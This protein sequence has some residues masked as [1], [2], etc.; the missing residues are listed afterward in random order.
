MTNVGLAPSEVNSVIRYAIKD[1]KKAKKSGEEVAAKEERAQD[2]EESK[3]QK[4]DALMKV[5]EETTDQDV[6]DAIDEKINEINATGE[7]KEQIK[8]KNKEESEL[9]KSLLVD[10]TTGVEYDTESELKRY[11]P[12]LWEENF[13]P[14]SQWYEDHKYEKE[15]NKLMNKEIRKEEDDEYGYTAP[16]KKTKKRN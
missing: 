12:E 16:A 1:A 14:N 3:N 15:V 7:E 2:R 11:N 8:Q 9:K 6:L 4:V 5:R 13:G 10:P